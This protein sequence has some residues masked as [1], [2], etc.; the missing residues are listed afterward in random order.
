MYIKCDIQIIIKYT[1]LGQLS[2]K[3]RK[4]LFLDKTSL[5]S[6][7][8]PIIKYKAYFLLIKNY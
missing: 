7:H 8:E 4:L 2:N 6:I 5:R 3:G 1:R